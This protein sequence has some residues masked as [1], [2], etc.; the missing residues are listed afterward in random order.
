[1]LLSSQRSLSS[2]NEVVGEFVDPRVCEFFRGVVR[3]T[4]SASWKAIAWSDRIEYSDAFGLQVP[5]SV[6]IL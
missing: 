3:Q 5:G 2:V 6:T 1:M 4:V